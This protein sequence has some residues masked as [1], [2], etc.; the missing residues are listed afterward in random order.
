M[1]ITIRLHVESIGGFVGQN[2]ARDLLDAWLDAR[3]LPLDGRGRTFLRLRV[4][5][6]WTERKHTH[7]RDNR[8]RQGTPTADGRGKA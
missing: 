3:E 7:G 6:S 1:T 2:E 8:S 4:I 5:D